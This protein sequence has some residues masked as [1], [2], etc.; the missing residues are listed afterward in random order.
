MRETVV[1]L[2][3]VLTGTGPL[4]AAIAVG[5]SPAKLKRLMKDPEFAEMVDFTLERRLE[6][7]EKVLWELARGGHFKSIQMVLYNKRSEEWR[8]VRHIQVE[9]HD[10]LDVGVVI[11][12]K[13]AA[14]EVLRERGVAALQ[15]EPEAIEVT[16]TDASST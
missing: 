10:Q 14:L 1:F 9:R 6:S 7:V 2:E 4:N 16:S 5:W 12:V 11:S 3:D 8:D 15:R 13:Q